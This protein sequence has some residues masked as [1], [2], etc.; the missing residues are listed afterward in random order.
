MSELSER[1]RR[2]LERLDF[3]Q[4]VATGVGLFLTLAGAAYVAWAVYLFDWRVDPRTQ[5]SFDGPIAELAVL[6]DRYQKI[7]DRV[8]PETQTEQ[9]MLDG[10][11]RGMFFSAG[12][13]VMLL[14]IYLGT[15]VCLMGLVALTVVVERRRLLLL[16]RKLQI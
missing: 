12:T 4:R 5:Q 2:F 14:R 11:R 6:Y 15:L 8:T 16:I 10:V 13:I 7:L 9:W 3:T 1:E